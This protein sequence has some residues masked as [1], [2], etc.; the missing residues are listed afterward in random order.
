MPI[1]LV[2]GYSAFDQA[3]YTGNDPYA[4]AQPSQVQQDQMSAPMDKQ[5]F[6]AAVVAKTLDY[7]NGQGSSGA[8]MVPM[9]KQTFGAAVVT[10]TLDYM[11]SG[12]SHDNGM[13]QSYDFQ[14]SVLGGHADAIGAL[15]NIKV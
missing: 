6:G 9:D 1:D 12:N 4:V 2:G 5:T 3:Q 8:D 11:N 14:K 15:A 10:K 7:L 13:S